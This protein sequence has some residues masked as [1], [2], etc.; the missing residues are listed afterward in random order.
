[1]EEKNN[2]A[3]IKAEKACNNY[4]QERAKRIADRRTKRQRKRQQKEKKGGKN[5]RPIKV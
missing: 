5:E 2:S 3:F 1:M 4:S